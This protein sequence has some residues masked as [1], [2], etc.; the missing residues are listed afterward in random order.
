MLSDLKTYHFPSNNIKY[1]LNNVKYI[2]EK[3]F[4]FVNA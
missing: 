2:D 1:S 4:L 3:L